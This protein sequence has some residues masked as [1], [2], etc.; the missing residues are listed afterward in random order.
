MSVL[1]DLRFSSSP[2]C[3]GNDNHSKGR[4][5][6][7]VSVAGG[8]E[9]KRGSCLRKYA[10]SAAQGRR[11]GNAVTMGNREGGLVVPHRTRQM[12]SQFSFRRATKVSAKSP[13]SS[14]L[15]ANHQC[16]SSVYIR[17]LRFGSGR[18]QRAL[19]GSASHA[20]HP[21]CSVNAHFFLKMEN[22]FTLEG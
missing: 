1:A 7:L 6:R 20:R 8:D 10:R 13:L 15:S 4:P 17:L 3:S 14:C 9:T 22:V 2:S 11:G 5:K 19:R 12:M 16:D 18:M 21:C